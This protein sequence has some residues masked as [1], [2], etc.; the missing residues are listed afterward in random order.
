MIILFRSS[1]T[2]DERNKRFLT[3]KLVYRNSPTLL[4][5]SITWPQLEFQILKPVYTTQPEHTIHTLHWSVLYAAGKK[6]TLG[7]CV[8][9]QMKLTPKNWTQIT[10]ISYYIYLY[11]LYM[12]L[13]KQER[14]VQADAQ[15]YKKTEDSRSQRPDYWVHSSNKTNNFQIN[16]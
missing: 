7:L 5:H 12:N 1:H 15:N 3:K 6:D 11:I 8:I 16:N 10:I 2:E 14:G 9:D 4:F 13:V